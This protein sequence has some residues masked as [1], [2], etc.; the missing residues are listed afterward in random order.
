MVKIFS[1]RGILLISQG[2]LV[3]KV[4]YDV[5]QEI[6]KEF[7]NPAGML[8]NPEKKVWSLP[9]ADEER[10]EQFLEWLE[11]TGEDV[12]AVIDMLQAKIA[13]EWNK[14]SSAYLEKIWRNPKVISKFEQFRDIESIKTFIDIAS[15]IS[16]EFYLFAKNEEEFYVVEFQGNEVFIFRHVWKLNKL[17]VSFAQKNVDRA[18]SLTY[19]TSILLS[20]D[21]SYSFGDVMFEVKPF[22]ITEQ[23]VK[24]TILNEIKTIPEKK[25]EESKKGKT[26]KKEESEKGKTKKKEEN[27]PKEV[28]E[29]QKGK[30]N[31]ELKLAT[32]FVV[33]DEEERV[34]YE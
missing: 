8:W 23:E 12:L 3:Y 14:I 25:K 11:N 2:D 30:K 16:N 18:G 4:P 29:V 32:V 13:K 1:G 34:E 26:K 6:V 33:S 28:Q 27:E 5:H 15:Y 7:G 9:I 24:E 20:Q 17:F 10:K 21:I 22:D 19:V 31:E